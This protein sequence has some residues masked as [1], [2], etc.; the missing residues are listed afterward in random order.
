VVYEPAKT[1]FEETKDYPIMINACAAC[2]L[3]ARPLR[4]PADGPPARAG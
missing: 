2:P 4:V 1:G 3:P